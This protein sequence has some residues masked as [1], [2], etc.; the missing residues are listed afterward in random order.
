MRESKSVTIGRDKYQMYRIAST[1]WVFVRSKKSGRTYEVCQTANGE[2]VKLYPEPALRD[3]S[4]EELA[5]AW[6][7]S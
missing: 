4:N 7:N 6:I 3:V 1:G 5:Q 2:I